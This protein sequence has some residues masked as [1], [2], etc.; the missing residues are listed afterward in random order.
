MN[1]YNS[2]YTFWVLEFHL[3]WFVSSISLLRVPISEL[4]FS[5]VIKS[6]FTCIFEDTPTTSLKYLLVKSKFV[7]SQER[8]EWFLFSSEWISFL[9]FFTYQE[10]LNSIFTIIIIKLWRF[11]LPVLFI[12]STDSFILVSNVHPGIELKTASWATG[13]SSDLWLWPAL[14]LFCTCVFQR[15]VRDVWYTQFKDS[16]FV[17]FHCWISHSHQCFQSTTVYHLLL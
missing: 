15:P 9:W 5:Y 4:W 3:L 7:F 2:N 17:T 16:L 14:S 10:I 1:I 11:Y 12:S 6:Y 13:L 8:F